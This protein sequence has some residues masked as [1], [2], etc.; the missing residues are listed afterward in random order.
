M[1]A[2]LATAHLEGRPTG[3]GLPFGRAGLSFP[4]HPSRPLG[5]DSPAHHSTLS[6]TTFVL[7][8]STKAMGRSRELRVGD[9]SSIYLSSV[10]HAPP[11]SSRTPAS[12][13]RAPAPDDR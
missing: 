8:L 5:L 9:R 3:A 10:D 12:R 2:T 11:P 4:R 6:L 13:P 1:T 7:A